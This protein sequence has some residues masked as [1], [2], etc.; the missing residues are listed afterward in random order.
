MSGSRAGRGVLGGSVAEGG[1]HAVEGLGDL[2]GLVVGVSELFGDIVREP[3]PLG[4]V[5]VALEDLGGVA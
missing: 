1:S 3:V 4:P 2:L 5:L